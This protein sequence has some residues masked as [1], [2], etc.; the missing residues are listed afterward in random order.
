[1][2]G[3]VKLQIH[4]ASDAPDTDFTASLSDVFPDGH[5][6]QL[7][8]RVTGII[9]ARYRLGFD[10]EVLLKPGEIAPMS[11]DL[12]DIGHTFL[13]GHRLRIDVSSSAYPAFNVNPNTGNPIATDTAEPRSAHQKIYHDAS[14]ASALELPVVPEATSAGR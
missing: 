5:A 10:K 1:V 12:F 13:A 8:S 6:V 9:R 14:H 7:G 3:G 2:I 11:I 4:A